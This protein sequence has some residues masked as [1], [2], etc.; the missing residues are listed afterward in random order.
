MFMH[1]AIR[2]V[3]MEIG[4]PARSFQA[5]YLGDGLTSDYDLPK[6]NID[7]DTFTVQ[8]INGATTTTLTLG[9]DYTINYQQGYLQLTNPVPSG[10]TILA[11]GTAWG[12]FTDHELKHFVRDAVRQHCHG[13]TSKQ[14]IRTFRGFISYQEEPMNLDNLPGIEEPLLVML[15]TIN[16]LWTLANDAA[17]DT[18]IST[19]EGTTVDRLGR[20]R[21]L[22]GHIA[23]LTERYQEYS[24]QLNVGLYRTETRKLR[25][26]SRT[27]GR[28]VPTFEDREYDDSRWPVRELPAIDSNDIDDSG[29]PS[30]LWNSQGY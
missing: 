30:P 19:A 6:Q 3:R 10:A 24:G 2:K 29:I 17:T 7:D 5:T 23:E 9:P 28:Y 11:Q 1:E 15:C 26:V 25:R 14:R 21:Q 18:D 22:M 12:L 8:I 13:R 27:T 20:Y 16:V 4:D